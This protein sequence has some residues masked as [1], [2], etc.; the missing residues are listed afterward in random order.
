[1]TNVNVS[2]SSVEAFAA[3]DSIQARVISSL[4]ITHFLSAASFSRKVGQLES[5][6]VGEVFGDFFEEIHSYSIAT[7]FSL[8]AALEA[9]A[10]E[11]FVLYK[12][13]I[14]PDLRNDVVAKLWEL[15]E[16]KPTVEKYDLA[17]FLANKSPLGKGGRPYQDIDALI[18]LR[19]GL[20]HYRPEW[21]DEQV[22]HRKISAAISGKAIGSSFYS[23]ETPLFP[24][25]W[26]SHGTVLWALNSS[27]EFVEKF[28]SQMGIASNLL[29][30]KDRLRG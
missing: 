1:M 20:V 13:V 17:L 25:A 23:A 21:S 14:F 30:F 8:V 15:Y 12:D 5:D 11:L 16:K 3:V 10:N 2:V 18:K 24:R 7:I 6:H 22:E 26:S 29:P 9:Y 28:E 27:I 4:S 19:N